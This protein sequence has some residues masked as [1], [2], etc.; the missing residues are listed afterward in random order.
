MDFRSVLAALL[1]VLFQSSPSPVLVEIDHVSATNADTIRIKNQEISDH[2]LVARLKALR[3]GSRHNI[4]VEG[5]EDSRFA[6][7]ARVV[8]AALATGYQRVEL[9]KR[10]VGHAHQLAIAPFEFMP[11][12]PRDNNI[13]YF[14]DRLPIEIE[15]ADDGNIWIDG[16]EA[17]VD[18]LY[19]VVRRAVIFHRQ[20]RDGTYKDEVLVVAGSKVRWGLIMRALDAARQAGDDDFHLNMGTRW[21]IPVILV[22]APRSTH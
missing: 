10:V 16:K 15:L 14:D 13:A 3:A 1:M 19:E 22:P 9:A 12:P 6:T 2:D 18:N 21:D 20:N 5:S 4:S 8:D 17:P 11:R 7:E